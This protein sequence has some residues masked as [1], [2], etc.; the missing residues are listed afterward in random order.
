MM[1]VLTSC[2]CSAAAWAVCFEGSVAGANATVTGNEVSQPYI[3]IYKRVHK[4][5]RSHQKDTAFVLVKYGLH[6]KLI[7][8]EQ[9]Q[10]L[11]LRSCIQMH[12]NLTGK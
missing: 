12:P 1:R 5:V 6:Y 8:T 11:R 3:R 4:A 7:M 9:R 10:N 2:L